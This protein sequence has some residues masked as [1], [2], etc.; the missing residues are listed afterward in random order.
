MSPRG[1]GMPSELELK[2][3]VELDL[4]DCFLLGDCLFVTETEPRLLLRSFET[5]I[6]G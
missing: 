5:L 6:S 3:Q 1:V 2:H 4:F